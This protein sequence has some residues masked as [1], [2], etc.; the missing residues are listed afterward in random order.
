MDNKL[1]EFRNQINDI[2]KRML[3][4]I[5]NRM[6]LSLKIGAYKKENNIPIL[7]S[8]RENEVLTLLNKYNEDNNLNLKEE[9]INE[10]WINIM[11]Y[12]KKIQV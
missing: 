1:N 9:F 8:N 6:I 5:H 3:D 12:S 11:S 7:N 2:D 10:L 4:L